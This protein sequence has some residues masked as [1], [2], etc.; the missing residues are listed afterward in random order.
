[1]LGVECCSRFRFSDVLRDEGLSLIGPQEE[2]VTSSHL[3]TKMPVHS[4]GNIANHPSS[5]EE[6]L[7][8][9]ARWTH[10]HVQGG[11]DASAHT[12][13]SDMTIIIIIIIMSTGH[14][15]NGSQAQALT[16]CPGQEHGQESDLFYMF[17]LGFFV[18]GTLVS[19]GR[20]MTLFVWII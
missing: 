5:E 19:T 9:H 10:T 1:M 3:V 17:L 2:E 6:Y 7:V 4:S 16:L 12:H 8:R 20:W 18:E 14:Q 13:W 15:G 11:G